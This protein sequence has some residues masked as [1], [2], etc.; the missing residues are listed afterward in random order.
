M[1]RKR[2][3]RENEGMKVTKM[4][5]GGF[6]RNIGQ[7]ISVAA[8]FWALRDGLVLAAQL[9]INHLV[10]VVV[11]LVLSKSILISSLI[12]NVILTHQKPTLS[13]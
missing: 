2:K 10:Q 4:G 7:A 8:K 9:G 12:K 3:K 13:F 6:M 1:N 5:N 11:N